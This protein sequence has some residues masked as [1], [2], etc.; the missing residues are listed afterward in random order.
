MKDSKVCPAC[1]DEMER[2]ATTCPSCGKHLHRRFYLKA[3]IVLAV[4]VIVK[5]ATAPSAEQSSLAL[6]ND[7]ETLV[8]A[9]ADDGVDPK[10]LHLVFA[11]PNDYTIIQRI[12]KERSVTGKIVEWRHEV[13][14]VVE[15]GPNRYRVRTGNTDVALGAF[16]TINTRSSTEVAQL[17]SLEAGDEIVFRGRIAGI[18]KR[19]VDIESAI[20]LGVP[21]Y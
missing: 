18:T 17:E 7:I 15:S 8:N 11:A 9:R 3:S 14:E 20:L 19:H 10:A 2:S 12:Y 4:L 5:L 13:R 6:V 1:S 16:V 21:T